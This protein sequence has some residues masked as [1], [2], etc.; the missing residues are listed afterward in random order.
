MN[1]KPDKTNPEQSMTA[2]MTRYYQ[3]IVADS[4]RQEFGFAP[5]QLKKIILLETGNNGVY[6]RFQIGSHYYVRNYGKIKVTDRRG[7]EL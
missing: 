5:A 2:S 7:T 3:K 1:E 6:I 4:L